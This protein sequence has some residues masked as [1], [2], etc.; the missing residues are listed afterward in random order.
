M[1]YGGSQARS[2]IGAIAADLHHSHSNAISKP[3]LW[4]TPQLMATHC[5]RPEIEPASSWMLVRFVSPKPW[6]ELHVFFLHSSVN[7]HL[8]CFYFSDI[9]IMSVSFV[10]RFARTY[11]KCSRDKSSCCGTVET[12]PTRNHEVA[13]LIPGFAQCVKDP[14]L[15]WAVM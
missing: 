9:V 7:G 3:C 6:W 10:F 1:A 11:F 5:V 14:V 4:P 12:N 8:N 15:P 2:Q 13:G